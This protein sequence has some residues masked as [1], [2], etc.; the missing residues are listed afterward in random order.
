MIYHDLNLMNNIAS[1]DNR[2]S[3]I[4]YNLPKSSRQA[5][6]YILLSSFFSPDLETTKGEREM[7]F[8]WTFCSISL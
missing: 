2:D 5:S 8:S 3:H 1:Q 4:K 7:V 6:S